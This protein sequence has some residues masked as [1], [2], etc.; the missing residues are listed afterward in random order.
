MLKDNLYLTMPKD[1]TIVCEILRLLDNYSSRLYSY[2][3]I[4][5]QQNTKLRY[6]KGNRNNALN[7]TKSNNW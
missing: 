4:F 6:Y 1:F 7:V 3:N 5:S 2:K